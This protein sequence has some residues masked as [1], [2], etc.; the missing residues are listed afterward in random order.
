MTPVPWT[1]PPWGRRGRRAWIT[2][3]AT[4]LALFTVL[5]CA[6]ANAWHPQARAFDWLAVALLLLAPAALVLVAQPGAPAVVGAVLAVVGPVTYLALGYEPG[7]AVVPLG[8]VV[9]LLGATRRRALAWGA[10]TAAVVA[11]SVLTL[12]PD[13]PSRVWATLTVAGLLVAMLLGEGARGRGERMQALRAA[14]QSREESA[15]AAERL[16]IA[17][18]LHDVLAHSLSG[19]TVQAGVGLHLMDREPEAARRA[20]VEI[21]DASKTALDEVRDV[22]GVLRADGE[23]PPRSPAGGLTSLVERAR[24]D[25]LTVHADGLD[26]DLSETVAA[27]VHRALQEALTNVRRHAPGAS[28]QVTLTVGATVVLEVRDD[29]PPVGA[30]VEGYGLQGMRERAEAVGGSVR[31]DAGPDGFVVHVEVPT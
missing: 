12:R 22:L 15:V 21:R 24:A 2:F 1:G 13:G 10:G 7:P 20:L 6:G 17:R 18:E 9:V 5:G 30:L 29:G 19:I 16:R 3:P 11:V 25:G 4:F 26:A 8:F 27:V 28:V 23:A 14:R 31:V